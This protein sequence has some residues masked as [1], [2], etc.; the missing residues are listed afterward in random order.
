M[1]DLS[2]VDVHP[3]TVSSLVEWVT[4]SGTGYGYHWYST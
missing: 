3:V 4:R 2:I 1:P